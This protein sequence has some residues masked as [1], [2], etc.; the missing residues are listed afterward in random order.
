MSEASR[1]DPLVTRI[2][3]LRERYDQL[4]P[5]PR[6]VLKRCRTSDELRAVGA[7]WSL[8]EDAGVPPKDRHGMA[9]VVACFGAADAGRGLFPRWLRC[10]VYAEVKSENL[11]A[12]AGRVR[13]LLAAR[14]RESLIHELSHVLRHGFQKSSRGVDW[15]V[16]GADIVRWGD[17]VR[18]RWAEQFFTEPSQAVPS[19]KASSKETSDV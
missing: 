1:E 2:L 17:V 19:L 16:L 8:L 5:G 14:D 7:F 11:V 4:A 6:A 3:G 18:R 9:Y 13:R 12:R 15:G 10:T